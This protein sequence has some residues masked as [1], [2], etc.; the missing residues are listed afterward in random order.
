MKVDVNKVVTLGN[1]E[2]YLVISYV[3]H[4]N[5]DYY[6]IAECNNECTDIKE[7]YKIVEAV[8]DNEDVYLEE[9]IGE[10]NLKMVLPLFVQRIVNN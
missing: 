3:S 4:N 7:N 2:N 10:A 9:V 5:R 1:G 8:N 6:Y